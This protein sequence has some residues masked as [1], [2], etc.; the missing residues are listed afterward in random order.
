MDLIKK[1]TGKNP[2]EYEVIA[3]NL[4]DNS[5]VAL[6]EKL[7]KQDDFLFDFVKTNVATRIKNACTHDNY[8]NLISF[9]DVYSSSYDTV[10]AQSLYE[11]GGLEILPLIKEIFISGDNNKKAYAAKFLSLVP[12][13]NVVELLPLLR[14]TA[15][16]DFEPLS[17]N[18]IEV[19]S[20]AN[21]SVFK[22]EALELLGSDD[23]FEQYKG[24][25]Y[26]VGL[27]AADCLND[28]IKVMKKSSLSENIA[29][30]IP[31]LLNFDEIVKSDDGILVLCN[32]INAI[33]EILPPSSVIN[34]NL[35]E[36]LITLSN[37]LT[38]SSALLLRMAK[39]KFAEL[40]E[41]EEYLF[42]C[43][44]NTK[45]EVYAINEFLS[46]I[47]SNKLKSLLY[48]ELF[49]ESDFVFFAIDYVEEVEELETLIDSKNP[50]LILK[51][52]LKLK[53]QDVLN[54][55]HK[56]IASNLIDD[57]NLRAYIKAL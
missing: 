9:F 5:D 38:S 14:N 37:N 16:S 49:E 50:T 17:V 34:Y 30:E 11:F 44:K 19:L 3:K 47:N 25:C 31:Y 35:R 53:E 46:G 10:I 55:K 40:T 28:I 48:D 26:L 8:Q 36:L 42:D 45:D 29:S 57:D 20:R 2:V 54:S 18:S 4:V 1:L 22:N 32:I 23:E 24:V 15:K 21:D 6:F 51:V 27:K 56:Q 7:V 41:N 52:L 39:E 12:K 13:E 33:P 43:D